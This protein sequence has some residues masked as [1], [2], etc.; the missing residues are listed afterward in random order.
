MHHKLG[1]APDPDEDDL[2]LVAHQFP[3][4]YDPGN[5]PEVQEETAKIKEE[6]AKG[7]CDTNMDAVSG[8]SDMESETDGQDG[9]DTGSDAP[10]S[11][12]PLAIGSKSK[13]KHQ[14]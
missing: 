10:E 11:E 6:L 7:V 13:K 5:D 1:C 12:L 3:L 9:N 14:R 4:I 8:A 2:Y